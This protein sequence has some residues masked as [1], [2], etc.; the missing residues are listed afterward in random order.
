MNSST[1]MS[2]QISTTYFIPPKSIPKSLFIQPKDMISNAFVNNAAMNANMSGT[3]IHMVRNEIICAI[4]MESVIVG[5]NFSAKD[6]YNALAAIS[7][8]INPMIAA[9]CFTNPFV[10]PTQNPMQII[11]MNMISIALI[12]CLKSEKIKTVG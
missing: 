5:H 10:M 4:V 8:A 9:N 1:F 7:P 3:I 6:A 11:A 12:F 2:K